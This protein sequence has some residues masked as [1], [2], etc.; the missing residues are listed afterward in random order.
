MD[1]VA[2]LKFGDSAVA[3]AAIMGRITPVAFAA[4]F[5]LSGAIGPIIGQNA[6]ARNFSRVRETL[7]AAIFCNVVYVLAV[8]LLLWLLADFIVAAFSATETAAQL[9]YFY[10]HYLVGAFM[11]SGILFIANASFNNLGKAQ[12]ATL[13]NWARALL[14]TVPCVYFGARWYGAP[15]VMAGEAI[16]SMLFGCLAFAVVLYYVTNLKRRHKM[17]LV[18]E[19]AP[20]S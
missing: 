3:G 2:F 13:A 1:A 6:G 14:G 12:L 18:D 8:W 20:R 4:V 17:A 16:G 7:L 11:F 9:I 10:I 19:P 15:G 5:A